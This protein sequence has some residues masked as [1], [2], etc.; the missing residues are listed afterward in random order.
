[1]KNEPVWKRFED[2][3]VPVPESGCW[4][5]LAADKGED[6]GGHGVFVISGK[7]KMSA[8]RASWVLHFGSIPDGKSVLHKCDV[9]PCVNPA[10]LFLGTQA[11]NIADMVSKGRQRGA[12]GE[13]NKNSKIKARDVEFLRKLKTA[14]VSNKS[15]AKIFGISRSM[16][17]NIASGKNWMQ[18]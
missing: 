18:P 14:G 10:H 7:K 13:R 12:A 9:A 11:D 4:L 8:H 1:M 3:Y 5:W 16:V 15:L 6:S 17:W 2:K